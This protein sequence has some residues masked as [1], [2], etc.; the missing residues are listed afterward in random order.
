MRFGSHWGWP[1][2]WVLAGEIAACRGSKSQSD[3]GVSRQQVADTTVVETSGAQWRQSALVREWRTGALES[4]ETETFGRVVAIGVDSAQHAFTV[5][6]QLRTV[7]QFDQ[8]G[9]FMRSFGRPGQGPGEYSLPAGVVALNDGLVLVR[10]VPSRVIVYD[11]EGRPITTLRV[12]PVEVFGR[13]AL[14]SAGGHVYTSGRSRDERGFARGEVLRLDLDG[15]SHVRIEIPPRY[16]QACNENSTRDHRRQFTPH[17]PR[18]S[19]AILPSGA[20][21]VGCARLYAIDVIDTSG[22]VIR[23]VRSVPHA[24]VSAEERVYLR[25]RLNRGMRFEGLP[26][27][28]TTADIPSV[29]PAYRNI[30]ASRD[31]RIWVIVETDNPDGRQAAQA[32]TWERSFRLDVF[33]NDGRFL[34]SVNIPRRVLVDP[35]PV[36]VGKTMWAVELDQDGAHGL[37][38]FRL[39]ME[40]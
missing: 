37:S 16:Y 9:S 18:V 29:K 13:N 10:D 15:G 12:P 38:R 26:A 23:I 8:A 2:V 6:V 19:W 4:Q 5:D 34:G 11:P 20:V 3:F 1:L 25:D 7:R 14:F 32:E 28:W 39:E 36:I 22:R 21:A 24:S 31:G 17:L 35:E 40:P 30:L 33:E 27:N